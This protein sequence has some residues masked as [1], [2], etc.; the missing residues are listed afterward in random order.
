MAVDT[1]GKGRSKL[2]LKSDAFPF[3]EHPQK[4]VT[5]QNLD[6]SILSTSLLNMALDLQW[7]TFSG[8]EWHFDRRK[9]SIVINLKLFL[10]VNIDINYF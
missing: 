10:V 9:K 7:T 3:P 6:T 2:N 1:K 8:V 4:E 5:G